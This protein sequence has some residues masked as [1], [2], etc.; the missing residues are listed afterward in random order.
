M[1]RFWVKGL[2]RHLAWTAAVL[3]ASAG[4]SRAG[5]SEA[6]LKA[7]VEEQGRQIEL[8]KQQIQGGIRPAADT[9]PADAKLDDTAVKKIVA[10][11]L[12]D[13]PGSGMPASVQTGYA[14][15]TGFAIRSAP[16]PKYVNWTD[17]SKIPFELRIRGRIQADYYGYKVT[18]TRNHLTGVDTRVNT[19]PDF[20]QEEIKRARVQFTGNLF[21]PN[22][23]YWLEFDGNTRGIAGLAGGGV[24][25]T[26]G[27]NQ[28]NTS[29]VQGG[30][31]IATVDHAVRLFSAYVAYDMHPCWSYKGC[32]PDCPDGTVSYQPT[33]T[34][35]AGK[36]K[37]YFSYEEYMGSG[38]QQMVEYGMSEWFFDAD[39]D[40]LLMQA[41]MQ[42]K[43]LE[44]RLFLHATV[45]NGNESQTANLQMDDLPGFNAGF[46]YDFGGNWNDKAKKWDLYGPQIADLE[47]SYNPVVRVGAM[48]NLVPMDRRSEFTNAELNRIRVIPAAPGGTGLVGLL[49]G[50]NINPA[51]NASQ[52]ALDAVDSYSYETFISGKWRGFSFLADGWVRD[53]NN[54]RGR[55]EPAGAY[56]GNGLNGPILYSV[57]NAGSNT[58]NQ[59][60]LFPARHGLLDY[61]TMFQTGYFIVPKKLEIA[62][63]YSWLR[64]DSGDIR[65][66]GT[67]TTIAAGRLPGVPASAGAI[68]VYN[69]AFEHFHESQEVAI[70]FNYYFHGQFLK[71]QTD[72]SFYNGGNPAAGG[73]SPA[74]FIPGVDG[75]MVRSQIQLAF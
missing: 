10:D 51:N 36:F 21:G 68:R 49:N 38:N 17:E 71:W 65:G 55:R 20:S 56:P 19:S 34:L 52:F 40:N 9:K 29:G 28:I 48:M 67:F 75:Y 59:T 44:D 16:D 74:G 12:K 22:L 7:K 18:D 60:A 64:G 53:L 45:T 27:V 6:D 32:G 72:L 37:P 30:N 25:G 62:T 50:N 69:G 42:A 11:Y 54:F 5:D 43:L 58:L 63:R 31:T 41:G 15:T 14:P 73:Q 57:N 3:V 13:N 33:V 26:T 47:W 23:R 39:D 70:G 2:H 1:V 8:L 66:N 46:W 35:I 4:A 61:G 24:P